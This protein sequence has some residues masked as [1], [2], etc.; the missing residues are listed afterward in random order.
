MNKSDNYNPIG[1]ILLLI[2]I[3]IMFVIGA[4]VAFQEYPISTLFGSAF[5]ITIVIAAIMKDE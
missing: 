5:L 1:I 3:V 4:I 2:G